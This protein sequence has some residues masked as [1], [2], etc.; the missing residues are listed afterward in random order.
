MLI[1][2]IVHLLIFHTSAKQKQKEERMGEE[3]KKEDPKYDAGYKH[4]LSKQEQFIHFMQKY[5]KAQWC[6]DLKP[7]Q[8]ELCDRE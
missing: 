8:V 5:V 7:E 1:E 2:D 3:K 4:E 6:R